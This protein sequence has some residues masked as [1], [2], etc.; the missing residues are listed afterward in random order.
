[1][2]GGASTGPRTAEGIERIRRARTIHGRYSADMTKLR[3]LL[4]ECRELERMARRLDF[5]T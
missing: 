4:A 2:H 3:V 1:M 5:E